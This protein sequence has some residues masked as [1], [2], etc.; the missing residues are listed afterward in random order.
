MKVKFSGDE[1]ELIKKITFKLLFFKVKDFEK[2]EY[3]YFRKLYYTDSNQ[4]PNFNEI[5]IDCGK[6][7]LYITKGIPQ[8]LPQSYFFGNLIMIGIAEIYDKFFDGEAIYYV[9]DSYIY[10]N[11]DIDKDVFKK[12]LEELN[13]EL[14]KY[15]LILESNT[16]DSCYFPFNEIGDKLKQQINNE[17]YLIQVHVEDKSSYLSVK[18]TKT[19]YKYLK[20]LS[21]LASMGNFDFKT[22]FSDFEEIKL[23]EKFMTLI[24]A[25]REEINLCCQT[26]QKIKG[27]KNKLDNYYEKCEKCEKIC[28][29]FDK[30]EEY[31]DKLKRFKRFFQYRI[32]MIQMQT[33]DEIIESIIKQLDKLENDE[34]MDKLDND[35]FELQ[36]NILDDYLINSGSTTTFVNN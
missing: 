3:S 1:F 14:K 16:E 32:L 10:T 11:R 8:G 34:I 2:E 9:D 31:F 13:A 5:K 17:C 15:S 26:I 18:D 23:K 22:T 36:L 7:D 33:S 6:Q 25:I 4:S 28:T 12:V 21:R 30:Y 24:K 20:F 27:C 29:E 35:M 19:G